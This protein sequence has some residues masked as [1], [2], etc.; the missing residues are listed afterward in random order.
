MEYLV[1]IKTKDFNAMSASAE[2]TEEGKKAN[3]YYRNMSNLLS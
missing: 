3:E 2:Y 1:L